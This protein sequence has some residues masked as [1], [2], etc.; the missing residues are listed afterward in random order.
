MVFIGF[1][2]VT[3]PVVLMHTSP[4]DLPLTGMSVPVPPNT[5]AL[6]LSA[7]GSDIAPLT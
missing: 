1:K 3:D 6:N 7:L 5:V 2:A 4:V